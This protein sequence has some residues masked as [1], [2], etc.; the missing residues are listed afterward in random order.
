MVIFEMS[1]LSKCKVFCKT[2][3]HKFSTK[4]FAQ[5]KKTSD[6]GPKM[7]YLDFLGCD[8]KRY[9]HIW[10]Q[11]FRI[12]QNARLFAKMKILKFGK[13]FR[14]V[15]WAATLKAIVIFEIKTLKLVKLEIIA[16]RKKNTPLHI[17]LKMPYL[18]VFKLQ[19]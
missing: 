9:F 10:N 18:S 3:S 17:G 6:L 14:S 15:F 5:T 4:S 16:Q 12:C 19:I 13:C 7:P 1:T 8:L 11:Y 2:K